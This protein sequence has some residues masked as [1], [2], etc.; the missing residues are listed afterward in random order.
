M[1]KVNYGYVVHTQVCTN[2]GSTLL[3]GS[4]AQG[5]FLRGIPAK[6]TQAELR[7]KFEGYGN[8]V[9]ITIVPSR[10]HET[11]TAYVDFDSEAAVQKVCVCVHCYWPGWWV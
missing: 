4:E 10:T 7:A 11:Y 5:I 3:A 6:T 1:F 9:G 2:I 8:V